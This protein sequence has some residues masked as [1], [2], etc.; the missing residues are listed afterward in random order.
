M[1]YE[2]GFGRGGAMVFLVATLGCHGSPL[3]Q[4]ASLGSDAHGWPTAQSFGVL[5]PVLCLL[6]R[7]GIRRLSP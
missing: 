3:E 7:L 5:G 4:M 6:D 1:R 2:P